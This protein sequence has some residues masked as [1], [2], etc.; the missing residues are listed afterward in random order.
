MIVS[1]R[2]HPGIGI[3]RIGDS[4]DEFVIGPEVIGAP[5][6][7]MRDAGGALKRQ[8]ARFRVYGIDENGDVVDELTSDTAEIKWTVHVANRKAAWYRF[9]TALDIPEAANTQCALRNSTV[10]GQDRQR[11]VIDPGPKSIA[12]PSRSGDAQLR[13]DGGTFKDVAVSLGELRT[14]DRGRLLVLGGHGRSESPG[15]APLYI[16]AD[17]GSFNNADDWFDDTSDGPVT[18]QVSIDGRA[19]PVEGAW[20]VVAPPDYAPDVVGW[21]TMADLLTDLYVENGWLPKPTVVRF[22]ADVLPILQRLTNLQWVNAGFAA[23][24]GWG[25]PMDFDDPGFIDRLAA[26]P[27]GSD[28]HRELRHTLFNAFRA[29]TS[30]VHEPRLWPWI[31][32]DAFGSF[33][34]ASPRNSLALPQ[35]Q[36][37]ILSEWA[38]GRFQRDQPQPAPSGLDQMP[39]AEQ[40]ATLDRAALT[41]CLADA[42]HPGCELTWPMRRLSLYASA[43]RIQQRAADDPEP[44]LGPKLNQTNALGLNGPLYAQPPGGLTRW[45][46]LP[47]QGDTAFCRS[48]YQP[49]FDPYLPTFWPARVPNQVLTQDDYQIATD[50]S[51]PREARIDAYNRREKWLRAFDHE[52]VPQAMQQMVDYFGWLGVIEA[53]EGVPDDPEL[54]PVML[55]EN[56]PPHITKRLH[57]AAAAAGPVP[58]ALDPVARAGWSSVE[59]FQAFRNVRMRNQ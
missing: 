7:G 47:W 13:L 37:W 51:Q 52:D 11:L 9:I 29:L 35:L 41:Y 55:V 27:A 18:A 3:A 45:M 32:G 34:H 15:D 28:P 19:I 40:P 46:A 30:K 48:G 42:F 22:H 38:A 24:F 6:T 59:Q 49:E 25:R 58:P 8:A 26:P 16:P 54:A 10:K 5:A 43:F 17:R 57:D 1:A 21:R 53:R 12:G 56:I 2:I 4:A 33:G 20:V 23:M 36:A 14:D 39:V 50:T 31:Y 44:D